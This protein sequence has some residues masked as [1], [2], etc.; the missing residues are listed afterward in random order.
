MLSFELLFV[1]LISI[2]T[3][4]AT[5]GP[6]VALVIKNA[7]QNPQNSFKSAFFT[8]CGT[9]LGSLVLISLSIAVILGATRISS[10]ALSLLSLLG[11]CFIFY[12]GFSSLFASK[13]KEQPSNSTPHTQLTLRKCFMQGL[14]L[15]LSNPKDILFFIAFF[16]QFI[17]ITDSIIFSIILLAFLWILLDFSLLLILSYFAQKAKLERFQRLITL[18]SDLVLCGIGIVGIIYGIS[19]LML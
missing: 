17:G 5:P 14:F 9:N 8:I 13:A 1:Y 6:V 12:L 11:S 3:L 10:L 16:P 15:S 19:H 4:I 2:I 18:F 7:L